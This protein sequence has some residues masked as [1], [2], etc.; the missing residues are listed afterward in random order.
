[1]GFSQATI[2]AVSPPQLR[3]NQVYVSWSSSSPAGTWFQVY[4]NQRLAWSGQRCWAWVPV[5]AGPVRIDIGAVGPGEQDTEFLGLAPL[6]PGAAGA[7]RL[8]VGERWD[9]P[10][11]LPRLRVGRCREA[12]S[13]YPQ[14]L[15]TS[16]PIPR[17]STPADSGSGHSGP[18]DSGGWRAI[19]PGPPHRSPRGPGPSPSSPTTPRGTR[20]R[21]RRRRSRSP[22]RPASRPRSRGHSSRLQYTLDSFGQV[23]FGCGGFGLPAINLSWNPSPA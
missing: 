3:G 18:G 4:V 17:A 16:P 15:P 13:I 8:A 20:G 5:P 19:T 12:R 22:R 1:M 23:R 2:E 7:D 10:G 6:G 21:R 11:G 9:G 14:S